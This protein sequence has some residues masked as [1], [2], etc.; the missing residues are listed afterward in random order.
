MDE[1]ICTIPDC[2]KP[3]HARGWCKIHYERWRKHGRVTLPSKE[4]RF[5][6]RVDKSGD[7]WLWTASRDYKGYGQFRLDGK[8]RKAHRV[9][10]QMLIGPIPVDLCIDHL[11]R[12]RHCVNPAHMEVVTNAENIRRG[13]TGAWER[14]IT[15]CPTGHPYDETNTYVYRGMRNCRACN[16]ERSRERRRREKEAA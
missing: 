12:V 14:A 13:R 11:C 3:H 1:R 5:W 2:G 8:N 4:E 16:R 10:Y 6:S 7:C 9:A 15:H